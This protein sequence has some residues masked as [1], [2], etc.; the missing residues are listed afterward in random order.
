M[1]SEFDLV[2]QEHIRCIQDGE[3]HNHYVGH[4]IQNELIHL[5]ATERKNH[6]IKKIK[7]AKY[8]SIILD[9]T[10]DA[11]HQEQMSFVLRYDTSG[12]GIF[13][14]L[15]D[16]IKN[17]D[18]DINNVRRQGYDNGCN[19]KGKEH[20]VQRILLDINPKA[21]YM[22]C[23]CHNLNLVI[24]DMAN[25]C[26][27]AISFFGFVQHNVSILTLKPLLQTCWESRIESIKAIKF[28]IP[29]IRE[30]L[31]QLAKMTEDSK[32]KINTVSKSMQSKDMHI[33]VVINQLK[34]LISYF[35]DY[36][37]NGFKSTMISSKEIAI[38]M[39]IELVF[40]EKQIIYR[41]KQFDEN[42]NKE[43]TQSA[44]ESFRINYFLFIERL[45]ELAILS[46]KKEILEELEYKNLIS[47]FASQKIRRIIFK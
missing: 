3:I 5:L 10:P 46:I 18:L 35:Q 23:G 16:T 40:R 31:L 6:I 8:F 38:S 33:D 24:C 13:N 37:E 7:D 19:M 47:N 28:Q 29:Q 12:K 39:E 17:L 22:P 2:M 32:T 41:K 36:G 4:D 20:G 9:C 26:P 43:T 44:K 42:V 1:I 27:E 11:S 21:F 45:N 15:L 34:G 30:T 25:S 14:E